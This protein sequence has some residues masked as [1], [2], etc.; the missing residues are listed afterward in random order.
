MMAN[1][2][3]LQVQLIGFEGMEQRAERIAED[4]KL[5]FTPNSLAEDNEAVIVGRVKTEA[6]D[7]RREMEAGNIP[8]TLLNSLQE[9]I[10]QSEDQ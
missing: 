5:L 4:F 3:A 8:M 9:F 6:R 7:L 10:T 1:A 2:L